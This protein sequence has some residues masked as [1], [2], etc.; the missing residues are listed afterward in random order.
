MTMSAWAQAFVMVAQSM[1][2]RERVASTRHSVAP[3][4]TSTTHESLEQ[5]L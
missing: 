2:V 5:S 1:L 3:F 4:R